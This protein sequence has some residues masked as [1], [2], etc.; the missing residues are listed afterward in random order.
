MSDTSRGPG[1]WQASDQKWYPPET[2]PD[3]RPLPPVVDLAT[4]PPPSAQL[5]P[6][7][8]PNGH[9]VEPQWLVCPTCAAP[10][11]TGPAPTLVP[12]SWP[13]GP[14]PGVD[15]FANAPSPSV[16]RKRGRKVIIGVIAVVALAAV[17][18][19]G[20]ALTSSK[21]SASHGAGSTPSPATSHTISGSFEVNFPIDSDVYPQ[22]GPCNVPSGWGGEQPGDQV[23]V[24]D[25]SGS[26]IGTGTLGSGTADDP[27][28]CKFTFSVPDVPDST[29]YG[30]TID[31]HT[32]SQY[33]ESQMK[34]NG[35]S[36]ALSMTP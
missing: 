29:F 18:G 5:G 30:F 9:T 4:T 6:T 12:S 32:S 23:Q 36:V 16:P 8:C 10:L 27:N 22:G 17:A 25:S 15:Q 33:G 26:T 7:S 1:W 35:W 14:L 3:N 20:Y 21:T 19:I 11:G 2:H 34:G 31:G 24:T 13:G 28:G